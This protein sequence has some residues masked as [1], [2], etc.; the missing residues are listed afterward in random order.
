MSETDA[1]VKEMVKPTNESDGTPFN[2]DSALFKALSILGMFVGSL[3]VA[4]LLQMYAS[5]LIN[6]EIFITYNGITQMAMIV[7]YLLIS[8]VNALTTKYANPIKHVLTGMAVFTIVMLSCSI[9]LN[10]N[11]FTYESVIQGNF[12]NW[13]LLLFVGAGYILEPN[14]EGVKAAETKQTATFRSRWAILMAGTTA[15]AMCV[16]V[17]V[18]AGYGLDS[19]NFSLNLVQAKFAMILALTY[20]VSSFFEGLSTTNTAQKRDIIKNISLFFIIA[21]STTAVIA[22]NSP[23]ISGLVSP[24]VSVGF[25]LISACGCFAAVAK[26]LTLD[27]HNANQNTW[28]ELRD[29]NKNK[30]SRYVATGLVVMGVGLVVGVT[31]VAWATGSFEIVK[32]LFTTTTSSI[33]SICNQAI[34]KAASLNIYRKSTTDVVLQRTSKIVVSFMGLL[35]KIKGMI[36]GFFKAAPA[37]II[38]STGGG[39]LSA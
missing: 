38:S 24:L 19:L 6:S 34:D 32:S 25:S 31:Y 16:V 18:N 13:L 4:T 3:V 26:F 21:I 37:A 27:S 22:V 8:I 14:T 9:P 20:T 1:T 28:I 29:Y 5:K 2:Y 23:E 7:P 30:V 36:A 33:E 15:T 11:V 35:S 17:C 12:F 10:T 39:G